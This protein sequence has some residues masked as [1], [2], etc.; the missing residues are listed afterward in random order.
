MIP[1]RFFTIK[2]EEAYRKELLVFRYTRIDP[3]HK[4]LSVYL[5]I[6]ENAVTFYYSCKGSFEHTPLFRLDI[7]RGESSVLTKQVNQ[8]KSSGLFQTHKIDSLLSKGEIPTI[9]RDNFI[10]KI[11]FPCYSNLD[12]WTNWES[13]E[14]AISS[15]ML[16]VNFASIFLDFLFDLYHTTIFRESPFFQQLQAICYENKLIGSICAKAEYYYQRKNL[17]SDI[18]KRY[19]DNKVL[20]TS[21]EILPNLLTHVTESWLT[22]LIEE[23]NAKFLGIS[24]WFETSIEKEV[25][26]V[27]NPDLE[28]SLFVSELFSLGLVKEQDLIKIGK[29]ISGNIV[30]FYLTRLNYQQ[31]AKFSFF[32]RD[33]HRQLY[34]SIILASLSS[35]F[36]LLFSWKYAIWTLAL[37]IILI[38]DTLGIQKWRI[39]QS[40]APNWEEVV[41]LF[42][43]RLQITFLI[44]WMGFSATVTRFPKFQPIFTIILY[45]FIGLLLWFYMLRES[46][47]L[48]PDLAV[49]KRRG[50]TGLIILF[51]FLLSGF[52]GVFALSFALRSIPQS[53]SSIAESW[54][55]CSNCFNLGYDIAFK[56]WLNTNLYV[57]FTGLFVNLVFQGKK[58]T[59]F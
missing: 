48:A 6:E 11:Y 52:I 22:I 41:N 35:V 46:K 27:I 34:I 24:P 21:N 20:F 1:G 17:F 54:A 28:E 49:G 12:C 33:G 59:G 56:I 32:Y 26:R 40:K 39:V 9:E 15:N 8:L 58:F 31:A 57:V 51:A 53:D 36:F 37:P 13:F 55:L 38:L 10:P 4:F 29:E 7:S 25:N 23:G 50:R 18:E 44:L 3:Q 45:I 43:P 16:S 30:D 47:K 14:P 19:R 5:T 2:E 42:M